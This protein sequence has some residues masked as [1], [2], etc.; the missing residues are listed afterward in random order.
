[1]VNVG[2]MKKANLGLHGFQA[3]WSIVVMGVISAS[4]L[5]EGRAGSSAKFMFTMCWLN[6]PALIYLIMTPRF[7]RTQMFAHPYWVI[8]INVFFSVLWFAAFVSLATY[9]N[10]GIANGEKKEKDD[11]LKKQGGCAVFKAGT[12]EAEKACQMNKS[13]IGLGVFMW[14][15]W[16]GTTAIAG[17]AAWYYSK[18]SVSPFEDLSTP[19][20]DIQ[21]TT[22]DAFSSNDEYSLINKNGQRTHDYDE[23]DTDLEHGRSAS[24]ASSRYQHSAY[25]HETHDAHPG[26]PLSWA[27]EREP[28]AGIGG[29]APIAPADG[30]MSMPHGPDDYSYQGAGGRL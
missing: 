18:H 6:V 8:G 1:M 30:G 3:L 23:D 20:H 11:K 9:T 19:S 29:H 21:E 16:L 4:M 28:Y 24:V 22:K 13:A 10:K 25:S 14:F 7:Q 26:R 2:V 17:Y 5:A 27:N 12:G 15:L